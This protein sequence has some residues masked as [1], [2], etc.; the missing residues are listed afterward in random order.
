MRYLHGY[1]IFEGKKTV[2]E[3][4]DEILSHDGWVDTG[5][6]D[7]YQRCL[8]NQITDKCVVFINVFYESDMLWLSMS[9]PGDDSAYGLGS[10]G[11]LKINGLP[12]HLK[13]YD[14]MMNVCNFLSKR[15][16][17]EPDGDILDFIE[18]VF[19]DISD[20]ANKFDSD[21]G[22][23]EY[24]KGKDGGEDY[25]EFGNF[26]ARHVSDKLGYG[27]TWEYHCDFEDIK[28]EFD[29]NKDRLSL[30]LKSYNIHIFNHELSDSRKFVDVILSD[31]VI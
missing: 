11:D 31:I 8:E 24:V 22:Y 29:Y 15:F 16:D 20:I 17:S 14:Q 3:I 12:S 19:V 13:D 25:I 30:Q 28:R 10:Y 26:P 21:W 2:D 4:I 18:D 6:N 7:I 23:L 5:S 1:K 27:I 9:K